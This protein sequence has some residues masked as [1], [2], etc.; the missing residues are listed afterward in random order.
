MWL[1]YKVLLP[2]FVFHW[3]ALTALAVA[4]WY[5]W[6]MLYK[7]YRF[8]WKAP[9]LVATTFWGYLVLTSSVTMY[10][11]GQLY[12]VQQQM[13]QAQQAMAQGQPGQSSQSS[14][15]PD[16]PVLRMKAEFLKSVEQVIRN[17]DSATPDYKKKV[18]A[19]FKDLIPKEKSARV[20]F[21]K[22]VLDLIS[23]QRTFWEDA[24]ASYKAKKVVKSEDLT[25]CEKESGSFFG[26]QTLLPPE[27]VK[28]NDEML[29]KISKHEPI[30]GP[31]GKSVELKEDMLRDA[32]DSE[33]KAYKAVKTFL[34]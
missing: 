15:L 6:T 34:E 24:M 23:C 2:S 25:A 9:F 3:F 10:Q 12:A 13:A 16:D 7:N 11:N 17:P 18:F 8:N 30:T 22:P 33:A 32:Y 19:D 14:T 26:R 20:V 21:S 28:H 29:E 31:D 4:A 27:A 5:F 1:Q